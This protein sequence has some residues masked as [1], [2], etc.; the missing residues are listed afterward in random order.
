MQKLLFDENN[1]LCISND[2]IPQLKE[3][4][5]GISG[6]RVSSFDKGIFVYHKRQ[7]KIINFKN[8]GDGMQVCYLQKGQKSDFQLSISMLAG[9]LGLFPGFDEETGEKYRFLPFFT[10]DSEKIQKQFEYF[11]ISSEIQK[12]NGRILV[13]GIKDPFHFP[14]N[15]DELVSFLFGMVLLYGKID[16]KN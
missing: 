14:N 3:Y 8:L 2:A 1:L 6:M 15:E 4:H 7:R 10:K 12:E 9:C 5:F 11:G 16:E 13:R